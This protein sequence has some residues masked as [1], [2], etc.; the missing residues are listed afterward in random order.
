[1]SPS[2][3][4]LLDVVSP[5]QMNSTKRSDRTTLTSAGFPS[6]YLFFVC[7]LFSPFLSFF[8]L[9]IE[10]RPVTPK[11]AITD[12]STTGVDIPIRDHQGAIAETLHGKI[13]SFNAL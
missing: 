4:A 7:P 1:M 6:F 8:G 3:G 13:F 5:I 11:S 12:V 2:S 9:G 10:G